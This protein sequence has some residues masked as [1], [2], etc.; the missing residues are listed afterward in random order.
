MEH[1]SRH[2]CLIYEGSP[3]RQLPALASAAQQMLRENYRCLYLNSPSMVVEMQNQLEAANVDVAH[4]TARA[5]LVLSSAQHHL[6]PGGRF[7]VD[8]MM[9]SLKIAVEQA[10]HDGYK[11]LW[12][13]GD[14]I[15]EFGPEK[16]FSQLLEYEWRLE[17]FFHECKEIS[18]VCQYRA[19]MLPRAV[20]RHGLHSHRSIFVSDK[21]SVKNPRYLRRDAFTQQAAENL[22]AAESLEVDQF[23]NHIVQHVLQ[24][25]RSIN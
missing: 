3:K 14:M 10:L 9:S 22:E 15:W 21:L 24:Q 25:Q 8:R 4:E 17:E 19:D 23:I 16:D 20:M 2:H 11:G 1:L 5:S 6:S 18:G 7:D 12:A 13:S